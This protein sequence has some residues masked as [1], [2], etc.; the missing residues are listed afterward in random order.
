MGDRVTT[1][2]S[3]LGL[4]VVQPVR[5]RTSDK[6]VIY[7]YS[8]GKYPMTVEWLSKYFN[9]TVVTPAPGVATPTPSPPDQGLVVALGRDYAL[10]WIGQ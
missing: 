4:K 3:P 7:D 1:T 8:G 10:R 5:G 6:S 9:A 2:L